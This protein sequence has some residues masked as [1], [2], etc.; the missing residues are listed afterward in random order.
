MISQ[1]TIEEVRNCHD[2]LGIISEYV[3]LRQRGRN[4]IGLCPFHNEKTP[5]FTVSQDKG[6]FHCFGCHESGDHISFVMK[7]D[8][9]T[10]HEAIRHIAA[11]KGIEVIEDN[12]QT[13]PQ[14]LQAAKDLEDLKSILYHLRMEFE[15]MLTP[16]TA[17]Y[18]YLISRGLTDDTIKQFHLGVCPSDFSVAAFLKNLQFPTHLFSKT[19]ILIHTSDDQWISRMKGRITFPIIDHHSRTVGFGGRTLENSKE[20]AKYVNSEESP[21]F[22]KRRLIYGLDQAKKAI[23]EAGSVIVVEGYMDVI[24]AHQFGFKNTVACMGTALT[25]DQARLIKRY[26][27]DVMLALDSDNAGQQAID[28]SYPVLKEAEL[29]IKIMQCDDKDPADLLIQKGAD[30]L[31]AHLNS[32][33]SMIEFK[34][35]RLIQILNPTNIDNIPKILEELLPILHSEK[36]PILRKHYIKWIA[37]QLKIDSEIIVAKLQKNSYNVRQRLHLSSINKKSKYEKA[38]EVLVY[39]MATDLT[40]RKELLSQLE[41]SQFSKYQSLVKIM[42][43]TNHLNMHLLDEI[44]EKE[45]HDQ[46]ARILVWGEQEGISSHDKWQGNLAALQHQEI[47]DRIEIL[48]ATIKQLEQEGKDAEVTI[49]LQELQTLIQS[50]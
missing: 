28:K 9:L 15:K 38:E 48:K 17:A 10:F 42:S 47:N 39:L 19:G 16:A 49:L 31:T 4:H 14:T 21:L 8:H 34:Y 41:M 45:V 43:Q 36:E 29:N 50:E 11:K 7:I 26:T 1:K 35:A 40:I 24:T 25:I 37:S 5:S 3:P 27:D 2:I 13:S 18:R 46:L 44:S 23:K 6:I 33:L 30:A 32:P 20:I 22:N 12:T